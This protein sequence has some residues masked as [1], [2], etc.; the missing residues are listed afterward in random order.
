MP[1]KLQKR[2]FE[3]IRENPSIPITKA[4]IMANYSNGYAKTG[5]AKLLESKGFANLRDV[6]QYELVKRGVTPKLLAK[7]LKEG[8]KDQDKKTVL[9]YTIEAKKDLEISKDTPDTAIQINLDSESAKYA[10]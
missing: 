4:M 7:K 2:A 1:T 10:E 9:A 8:L 3:I 6:Y 5:Q